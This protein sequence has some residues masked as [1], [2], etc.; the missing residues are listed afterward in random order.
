[1]NLCGISTP[2]PIRFTARF[3]WASASEFSSYKGM[4]RSQGQIEESSE[5]AK[6]N[7]KKNIIF[8]EKLK[9]KNQWNGKLAR[10]LFVDSCMSENQWLFY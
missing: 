8:S 3:A 5:A 4:G 10:V 6:K 2:S 1:M 9:K 7:N